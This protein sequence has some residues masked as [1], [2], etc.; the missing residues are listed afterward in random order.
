MRHAK[1]GKANVK[2]KSVGPDLLSQVDEKL[3]F[4]ASST[5]VAEFLHGNGALLD[6]KAESL[7]KQL[8]RYRQGELRDKTIM[9]LTQAQAKNG[10]VSVVKRL[11][12]IEELEE[13]AR[14]QHARLAKVLGPEQ[15]APLLIKSV[16]DEI[17]RLQSLLSRLAELQLE[18]GMIQRAPKT[19]KGLMTTPDGQVHPFSWTEEFEAL[20]QELKEWE[21]HAAREAA[22]DAI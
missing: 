18:T 17:D 14:V 21:R 10:M 6:V 4:G 7:R 3:K 13:L 1:G 5:E 20:N 11:N 15:K 8:D 9:A 16:G 19:I 22:S 2:L 12:A